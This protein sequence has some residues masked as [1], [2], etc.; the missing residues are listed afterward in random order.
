[1]SK[2]NIIAIDDSENIAIKDLIT[3][4]GFFHADEVMTTAILEVLATYQQFGAQSLMEA[5]EHR[6]DVDHILENVAWNVYRDL[7]TDYPDTAVFAFPLRICRLQNYEKDYPEDEQE[8][9]DFVYDIGLGEFDHHQKDAPVHKG[10]NRRYCALSL[11]WARL[12]M[13]KWMEPINNGELKQFTQLFV[14]PIEEADTEGTKNALSLMV[15]NYNRNCKDEVIR[16]ANFCQAVSQFMGIIHEWFMTMAQKTMEY[17]H[18]REI[19]DIHVNVVTG[20]TYAIFPEDVQISVAAAVLPENC[21]AIGYPSARGGFAVRSV[22]D[23]I[24]GGKI[25]NR[26]LYPQDIRNDFSRIPGMTFCHPSGFYGSFTSKKYA[27]AFMESKYL[28]GVRQ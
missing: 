4:G 5:Y 26:F 10:T 12:M 18:C 11:V 7:H 24:G 3:H 14:D 28:K 20:A 15:A 1:M 22:D 9:E 16:T 25:L 21:I 13:S 8:P 2:L 6:R 27:V 19:A 17:D 23:V